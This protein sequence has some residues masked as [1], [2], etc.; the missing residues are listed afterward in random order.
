MNPSGMFP[1]QITLMFRI[2]NS[3]TFMRLQNLYSPKVLEFL[4]I[5]SS[6]MWDNLKKR[7]TKQSLIDCKGC[8]NNKKLRS[9]LVMIPIKIP[10]YIQKAKKGGLFESMVLHGKTKQIK[11]LKLKHISLWLIPPS[12]NLQSF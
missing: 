8:L 3:N 12:V 9:T 6:K 1:S 5:F 7:K 2:V 10:A 4:E 11:I